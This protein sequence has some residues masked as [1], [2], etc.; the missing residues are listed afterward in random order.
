MNH[1]VLASLV[2]SRNSR[3]ADLFVLFAKIPC[4]L[5]NKVAGVAMLVAPTGEHL[6][7]G[8][9]VGV[10]VEVGDGVGVGEN[11]VPAQIATLM[12]DSGVGVGVLEEPPPPPQLQINASTTYDTAANTTSHLRHQCIKH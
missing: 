7:V 8:V 12:S 3:F 2:T 4:A 1:T 5:K 10:L 6:G 11:G 9:G